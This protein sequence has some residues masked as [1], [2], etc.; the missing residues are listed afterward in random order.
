MGFFKSLKGKV[1]VGTDSDYQSSTPPAQ[2][3]S[4]DY[5]ESQSN[6]KPSRS[7]WFSPSSRGQ[8]Q[9]STTFSPPPGPPPSDRKHT[10]QPPPGPPPSHS[11]PSNDN[12]PAYHDWTAVPDASAL[13]PPPAF[14]NDV[15]PANNASDEDAEA[16]DDWC[17]QYPP[18]DPVAP[19][20]AELATSNNLNFHLQRPETFAKSSTITTTPGGPNRYAVRTKKGQRDAIVFADTPSYIASAHHPLHTEQIKTIYYEVEITKLADSQSIVAL[21]FAA[22]PYPPWRLPG[23]HRAS[24]GVH[25][26]DGRRYANDSFGGIEFVR[27][28]VS[29]ERAGFGMR[30]TTQARSEVT[31]VVQCFFTRNGRKEGEWGMDEERDAGRGEAFSEGAKGLQGEGDL[32]AAVGCSGGTEFEVR[33]RPEDWMYQH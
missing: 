15:S 32:Y 33:F 31:V 18:Y 7:G 10:Y 25:S 12:P 3:S 5:H 28:L 9:T 13:P 29:G 23:W 16:A 19:T 26:D 11:V 2:N 8:T 4:A 24:V 1:E 27:P 6:T 22:K 14:A 20:Q 30:F 21:G 17:A